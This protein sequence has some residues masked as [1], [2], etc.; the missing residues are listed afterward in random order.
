MASLRE[1]LFLFCLLFVSAPLREIPDRPFLFCRVE[2]MFEVPFRGVE[3]V[4]GQEVMVCIAVGDLS[5]CISVEGEEIRAGI[6]K[7]DRRVGRDEEL[8]VA[9]RLEVVDDLQKGKLPLR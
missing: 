8:S 5:N 2:E 4:P 6:R 3:E 7:N 1:A 9:G